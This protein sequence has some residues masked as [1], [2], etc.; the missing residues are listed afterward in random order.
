M[1]NKKKEPE[2]SLA[3]PAERKLKAIKGSRLK[4][5]TA[6]SS[7]QDK[8]AQLNTAIDDVRQQLGTVNGNAEK[9]NPGAIA[10]L[11]AM[12]LLVFLAVV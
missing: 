7:R 3:I 12:K 2:Q 11:M 10:R 6:L 8:V 9:L 5:E 4:T 1:T